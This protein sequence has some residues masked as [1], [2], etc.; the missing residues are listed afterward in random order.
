[1]DIPQCHVI[2]YW[3]VIFNDF[4]ITEVEHTGLH[5]Q[6]YD[7]FNIR[8]HLSQV[9]IN[10]WNNSTHR[11]GLLQ[12]SKTHQ[13][14]FV[15]F[16]NLLL[17]DVT[18]LLD[19]GLSKLI[20]INKLQKELESEPPADVSTPVPDRR[21]REQTLSSAERQAASYISLANETVSLLARFT[22]FVPDAFVVPEVVDRL[23]RMLNFNQVVLTGD[24][25]K[26]LKVKDPMKYRFN[27]KDLL[28]MIVDIYL[29]LRTKQTFVLACARDGRS[30][31]RE[32]FMK[33]TVILKKYS[34]KPASDVDAF[35]KLSDAIEEAKV[36]DEEGEEALGEIPDHFLGNISLFCLGLTI[37][38][39]MYTIMEDPVILPTSKI[40]IDRSTIK[41]H[42]LSDPTDP[43]NRS[44]LKIE[45]V[46]P[47]MTFFQSMTYDR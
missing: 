27:P 18:Y 16:V 15:Q 36:Q 44:P 40:S 41:S 38:P 28:S 20:E 9:M 29:N 12:E 42:L 39:L 21:E 6:F 45:D 10:V 8:Y 47:G 33:T 25:C 13:D 35:Q 34:L 30:Y 31:R 11:K 7:K 2:L 32:V 24:K 37:D 3:S 46:L 23:A 1:M 26:N 4:L 5:S 14:R 43:F 22:N 17:N 19:E